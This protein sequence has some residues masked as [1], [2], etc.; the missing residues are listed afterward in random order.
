MPFVGLSRPARLFV[1]GL[2]LAAGSLGTALAAPGDSGVAAQ[3]AW[4]G[5]RHVLGSDAFGPLVLEDGTT[6][7]A[8]PGEMSPRTLVATAEGWVAAGV[9]SE[10]GD[11]TRL[12]IVRG[13]AGETDALRPPPATRLL[14]ESPALLAESGELSGVVWL[15]GNDPSRMGVRAAEWRSGRF[16]G[17]VWL[18]R[19][20]SR[21]KLGVRATVLDD[22]GWLAVWSEV[23]DGNDEIVFSWRTGTT[24]SP[25]RRVHA[26]NRVPDITPA[27]T[28]IEGGALAAWS[29]F[30]GER[31][32][33]RVARF[34]KGVWREER[35]E[36]GDGLFPSFVAA[37]DTGSSEP[38]L[39]FERGEDLSWQLRP[40]A[41]SGHLQAPLA[42]P[43]EPGLRP[44]ASHTSGEWRLELATARALAEDAGGEAP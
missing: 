33:L 27:V 26:R 41:A 18:S 39:L 17:A 12:L 24:W 44:V 37:G 10:R 13:D 40:V 38:A 22:G 28:A 6:R 15:E 3:S 11:R 21:S 8:L 19:P 5:R 20:G 4:A 34:E 43:G 2:A 30:D 23:V 31:Y 9:R 25:P 16:Q 32:G 7:V 14:Q 36:D 29:R 42:L 35:W 1:A